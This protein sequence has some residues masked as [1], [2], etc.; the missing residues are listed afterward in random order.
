MRMGPIVS[1]GLSMIV[2]IVAVVFGRAWLSNEAEASRQPAEVLIEEV[3]TQKILVANALI[4]RGDAVE[5]ALFELQDWPEEFLPAGA[6]EDANA[7]IMADG[8]APFA[9]GR[10]APGEPVTAS[11]ISLL[12]PRDTLAAIIEPGYRAVSIEVAD[13]TGV[14]GFVLPNHRVD[15]IL[16]RQLVETSGARSFR[17]ET[18]VR[19][20][21]VLAIDQSFDDK[22]DGPALARSVTLEVTPSQAGLLISGSDIGRMGLALRAE[23]D[24]SLAEPKPKVRTVRQAP[25]PRRA[26]I[27][28]IEGEEEKTVSAP[29]ARKNK[30]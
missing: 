5:A 16:S 2:G 18:V 25:R 7:L 21:R 8:S 11:K 26:S 12:K 15:V 4:E 10:I 20:V 9:L 29:A 23:E 17:P 27:R 30:N 22:T 1:L 13:D 6:F 28:I 24:I 3:A 19:N 14:A